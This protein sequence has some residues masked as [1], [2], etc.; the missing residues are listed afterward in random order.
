VKLKEIKK[1]L[2]LQTLQKIQDNYSAALGIPISIRDTQ[3]EL[4]TKFSN[5]SKLWS[6]IHNRPD[7]EAKLSVLLRQAIDKCNRTGQVVIFERVPDA[8]VF[9]APIH[10]NGQIIAFFV[11]G[12]VRFGNPNMLIAQEEAHL[13][14]IDLDS[15]LDAYLSLPFITRDRLDASAN[16]IKIIGNTISNLE[17]EDSEIKVKANIIQ[18]KNIELSNN[19]DKTYQQLS[20]SIN[21]YKQIF[22]TVNDG[23]YAADLE[24]GA[25]L[26]INQ[27]GAQI[28][29]Y[30]VPEEIRGKAIK[31]FYANPQ[32]R[33]Q[34]IRI[35]QEKGTIKH[36]IANIITPKGEPRIV[37]TNA[38]LTKDKNSGKT[39]I[40]G[41]FREINPR[42]HR[43]I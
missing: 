13:L 4:L 20:E 21:R 11:G 15:Y 39:L 5:M 18:Q 14:D 22:D 1:I 9:L 24:T 10:A 7:A 19:L 3:G 43:S 17:V 2:H 35:L 29:G 31:N 30:S 38:N 41:I 33:D 26:E 16:L 6:L 42:Q 37:E 23:I 25:I 32:D 36:W 40:H 8:H 12:L 28:L 34:F 27:A